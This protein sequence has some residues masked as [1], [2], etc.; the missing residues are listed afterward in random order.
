MVLWPLAIGTASLLGL[1][2]QASRDLGDLSTDVQGTRRGM[3]MQPWLL[4]LL[5]AASGLWI[6]V[7]WSSQIKKTFAVLNVLLS[8]TTN[9]KADDDQEATD[10]EED[11]EQEELRL[12]RKKKS[13]RS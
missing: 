5:G 10:S 8:S 13:R 1:N 12:K 3:A 9:D 7:T 2:W 11:E 4:F 6:G